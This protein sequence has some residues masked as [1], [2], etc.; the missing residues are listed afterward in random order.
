MAIPTLLVPYT[1]PYLM[2]RTVLTGCLQKVHRMASDDANLIISAFAKI[3]EFQAL[4]YPIP[5]IKAACTYMAATHGRRV[6]LD[7]RDRLA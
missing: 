2:K 4:L 5:M 3:R 6:W 7:I 1:I